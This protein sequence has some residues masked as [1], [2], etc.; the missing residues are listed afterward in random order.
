MPKLH[1]GCGEVYLPRWINIDNE[2]SK[3]DLRHDLTKP[4]P[5]AD[6]SVDFIY[7]EHFIEH[8]TPEEGEFF[9][10]EARRVLQKDGVMRIATPD[11]DHIVFKYFFRWKNQAWITD[12]GYSHLK[13]RAEMMNVVFRHWGHRW[14][15]NFEE[16]ERRL[17]SSGFQDVRREQPGRSSSTVLSGLETRK[18]SKLIVESVK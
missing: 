4:L 5:Y 14:L 9:L 1:I 3:A 8:L 12:Y 7:S 11:L 10:R 6:G 17:R 15:Y 13:T 2:S 18:D 16:L